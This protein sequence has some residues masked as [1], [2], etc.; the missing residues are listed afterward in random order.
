MEIGGGCLGSGVG[1]VDVVADGSPCPGK[2]QEADEEEKRSE[3][4][5]EIES[6]R[7][8]GG[9]VPCSPEDHQKGNPYEAEVPGA[10]ID[11][12]EKE[13]DRGERQKQ[14]ELPAGVKKRDDDQVESEGDEVRTGDGV[15]EEFGEIGE[16]ATYASLLRLS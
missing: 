4:F 6:W 15:T 14:Q 12:A 5:L 13:N 9:G 11:E 7:V 8:V 1:R 10:A 16:P 3:G 2:L